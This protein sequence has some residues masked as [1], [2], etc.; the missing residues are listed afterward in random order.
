MAALR[1]TI[2]GFLE[3]RST[4][5]YHTRG[6]RRLAPLHSRYLERC[7]RE[8]P[9][10][11]HPVPEVALALMQFASKGFGS[12]WTPRTGAAADAMRHEI[13][14]REAAGEELWSPPTEL[15]KECG[16]RHLPYAGN[17]WK[18]FPQL[19][20]IFRGDIGDFL[21]AHYGTGFKILF[22]SL[23]RSKRQGDVRF[24][25]QVWHFDGCPGTC[26]SVIFYLD[27]TTLEDGPLEVI[28][29][30][31]SL[32]LYERE[33]R[34]TA[35]GALDGDGATPVDRARNWYTERIEAGDGGTV[36]QPHGPA[37]LVVPFF[38]E[39]LHRGGYTAA[40]DVYRTAIVFDCYPS[41]L[42]TDLKRYREAGINK[43]PS[44]PYPRD[45]AAGF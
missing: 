13:A 37:G 21:T 45:P 35:S 19:E 12:F 31:K 8:N 1:T 43:D 27:D 18:D 22:G 44:M 39:T 9:A 2:V 28:A 4:R 11:A 41:H 3:R 24:G 23:Y 5:R 42:P 36:E 26:I 30:D 32:A 17:P 7:R 10:T 6:E 15:G 38:G 40:E 16:C 14:R 34:L 25:P 33:M 20:Q 29:L